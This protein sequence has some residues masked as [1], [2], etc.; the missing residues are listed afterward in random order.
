M[1]CGPIEGDPAD[2]TGA[3]ITNPTVIVEVLSTLRLDC[4]A[5][6]ELATLYADLPA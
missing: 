1:M 3:T 5:A 6:L 2:P 4:G